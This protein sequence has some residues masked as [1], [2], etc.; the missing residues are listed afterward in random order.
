MLVLFVIYSVFSHKYKIHLDD[1]H[2]Y[3]KISE[4]A[5]LIMY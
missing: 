3:V 2:L 5:Q 1:T 4:T